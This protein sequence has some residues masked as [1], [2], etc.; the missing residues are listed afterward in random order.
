MEYGDFEISEWTIFAICICIF[1][2]VLVIWSS[3]VDVEREKTKQVQ[4]Q[5]NIILEERG[6]NNGTNN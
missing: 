1:M 5:Y 6:N 4:C 3:K 2:S